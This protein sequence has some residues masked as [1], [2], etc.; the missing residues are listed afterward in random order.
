MMS[1]VTGAFAQTS[2][3]AQDSAS[4]HCIPRCHALVFKKKSQSDLGMPLRNQQ[5]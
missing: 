1:K 3:A 2:A 4:A 5:K